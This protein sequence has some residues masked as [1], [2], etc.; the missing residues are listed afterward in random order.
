[1][2]FSW[3]CTCVMCAQSFPFNPASIPR[4]KMFLNISTTALGKTRNM[5]E[6]FRRRYYAATKTKSVIRMCSYVT[7]V[8]HCSKWLL[9]DTI[10]S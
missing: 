3:S 8:I 1:M 7:G 9:G 4:K 2:L 6:H 5:N 10:K